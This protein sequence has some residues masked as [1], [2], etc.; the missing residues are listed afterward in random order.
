MQVFSFFSSSFFFRLVLFLLEE[1]RFFCLLVPGFYCFCFL[2]FG[3]FIVSFFYQYFGV[4]Q[5]FVIYGVIT[6]Y[7]VSALCFAFFFF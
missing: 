2:C 6:Y 4:E 1:G 5:C 7:L 3:I